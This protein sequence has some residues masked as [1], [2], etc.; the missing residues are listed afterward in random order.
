M[1]GD[2]AE[3]LLCCQFGERLLHHVELRR[4][5]FGIGIPVLELV[6]PDVIEDYWDDAPEKLWLLT[7]LSTFRVLSP[8]ILFYKS[9]IFA[10]KL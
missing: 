5:V 4:P 7:L 3:L 1:H 2:S 9:S 10:T 6:E 8:K